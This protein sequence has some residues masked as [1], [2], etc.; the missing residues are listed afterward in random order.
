MG[1][2][3]Q[4][5]TCYLNS[6]IQSLYH[7]PYFRKHVYLLPT[8]NDDKV[9]AT[10]PVALQ[11]LFYNLQHSEKS[12]STQ[13]LTK[14]FGWNANDTATQHDVQEFN[15]VLQDKVEEKMKGTP[16]EGT[17]EKMFR[18]SY[19]NFIQCTNVDYKSE[20]QEFFYDISLNVLGCSDIY[21]SFEKYCEVEYLNGPNQ[22]KTDDFGLQDAQKGT[23]FEQ[24]PPVLYLHLKRFELDYNTFNHYKVNDHYQFAPTINLNKYVSPN[25]PYANLDY[26]Y[27]L[28]GVLVHNGSAQGGHYYAFLRPGTGPQW[29]RF[30][31]TSV[32]KAPTAKAIEDNFGGDEISYIEGGTSYLKW[33]KSNSAYMLVY[34]KSSDL[35]W[36]MGTL[37][38]SDIP[39]HLVVRMENSQATPTTN[40]KA[41]ESL[42]EFVHVTTER[43]FRRHEGGFELVEPMLI[44][45]VRIRKDALLKSLKSEVDRALFI[46]KRRQK[47]VAWF[48]R[49]NETI[50]PD[51]FFNAKSLNA[52]KFL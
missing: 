20:R 42:Y 49:K 46:P 8:L 2:K 9:S 22:Y 10:I 19:V 7:L 29:Y 41:Q 12:V 33:T 28:H 1:I 13:E 45:Q 52:S 26:T 30:D 17:I 40:S 16:A 37:S 11:N 6:L 14:S 47:L 25:S 32:T 35:K 23:R 4:G 50:R 5:A 38:L 51:E 34:I 21:S 36:V 27:Q 39:G 18:G 24:F 31:D 3:N 15:R 43:D 48:S 44:P